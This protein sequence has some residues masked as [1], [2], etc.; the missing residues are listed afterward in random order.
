M[1]LPLSMFLWNCNNARWLSKVGLFED[2]E[3]EELAEGVQ[4]YNILYEP[5]SDGA[6]YRR[7]IEFPEE[8]N[9]I[10]ASDPDF[11]EY[12]NG[13]RLWQEITSGLT[14]VET[15]MMEK[16]DDDRTWTFSTFLWEEDQSDARE[17]EEGLED[18]LGTQHDVPALSECAGCHDNLPDKVAG[19]SALQLNHNLEGPTLVQMVASGQV[20]QTPPP[21]M[22]LPG[23]ENEVA[24]LGDLHVN[25]GICHNDHSSLAED[26]GLRL[27]ATAEDLRTVEDT[28]F[29]RTT[30]GVDAHDQLPDTLASQLVAPL[31]VEGSLVYLR[32]I[33][34]DEAGQMPPWGTKV[35][36]NDF[37]LNLAA[38]INSLE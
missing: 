17:V 4:A 23:E 27:W 25:C 19:F 2:I 18:A 28:P 30:V 6:T 26:Y 22:M 36:D 31:Q 5:W 33:R 20:N 15:R 13:T 7:W 1:L 10:D 32:V 12:P 37:I 38:W 24:L 11:W 14:R 34:R 21:P 16:S 8:E 35:V 29:Y 9:T 3:T